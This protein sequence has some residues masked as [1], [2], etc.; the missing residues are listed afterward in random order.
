[1]SRVSAKIRITL[2]GCN[3][4]FPKAEIGRLKQDVE[5]TALCCVTQFCVA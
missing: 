3:R 4:I 5:P 1:M 2:H